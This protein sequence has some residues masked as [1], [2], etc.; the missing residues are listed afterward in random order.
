MYTSKCLILVS[1]VILL[2]FLSVA[3]TAALDKDI[4]L[5]LPFD[6]GGGNKVVDQSDNGN[7]GTI[8]GNPAWV[9]GKSGKA[10]EFNGIDDFVEVPNSSTLNITG[11]VTILAWVKLAEG[12]YPTQYGHIAGINKVG[13]QTEDAYY[14][15]VG[16][17]NEEHDKVS[18][19]IIGKGTK[20]TSL[21]G[22]T[23]VPQGEWAFVSGVFSP[24]KLMRVYLN[25]HLDGERTDVPD[26][27]QVVPTSFTVGAIVASTGYSFKG[28]IDEVV[29][30]SRALNSTGIETVMKSGPSSVK[31]TGKL[32]AT[33]GK[34]K[35]GF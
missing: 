5:Y 2:F 6:E 30:Y 20:E 12:W 32:A 33:W 26:E 7:D 35:R 9:E 16:Y 31:F 28:A 21:Q 18:L 22:K 24:G 4:V 25:G 1:M 34:V 27:M 19:G 3:A 15:N 29:V 17:Y 14:L 8:Q 13:G 11:T 23:V 10:L